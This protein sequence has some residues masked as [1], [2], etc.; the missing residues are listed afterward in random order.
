MNIGSNSRYS[1]PFFIISFIFT[2][3]CLAWGYTFLYGVFSKPCV[4]LFPLL[5]SYNYFQNIYIIMLQIF[6][7]PISL[8]F[9]IVIDGRNKLLRRIN[10]M[11]FAF[12]DCRWWMGRIASADKLYV[13]CFFSIPR[14]SAICKK[15]VNNWC[16]FNKN[17]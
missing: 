16:Y 14:D 9:S 1:T 5:Q 12:F 15:A 10:S 3:L 8:I 2:R 11:L 4:L 6:I 13:V 17:E 7:K